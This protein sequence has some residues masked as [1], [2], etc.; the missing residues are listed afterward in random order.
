MRTKVKR[1]FVEKKP[2]FDIEATSL[3]KDIQENLSIK[4]LINIR[5]LNCYHMSGISEEEYSEAK[6]SIFSEITVDTLYE[7]H[8]R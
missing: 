2:G 1:I 7:E 6:D 5:L 4:S 3:L 8:L